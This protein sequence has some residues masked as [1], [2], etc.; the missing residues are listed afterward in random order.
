M[1]TIF[2]LLISII[3]IQNIYAGEVTGA[4]ITRLLRR[5]GIDVSKFR[6]QGL[7]VLVKRRKAVSALNIGSI[8]YYVGENSVYPATKVNRV[9]FKPNRANN[10][11]WPMV[12]SIE[13]NN[14]MLFPSDI[15]GFV[16]KKR[17]R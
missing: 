16:V 3:F 2:V 6:Q 9:E 7:D 17:N 14:L 8:K 12:E 10:F 15:K 5:Q 13:F 1:K 11:T 4:G